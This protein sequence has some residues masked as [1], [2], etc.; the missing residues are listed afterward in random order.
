MLQKPYQLFQVHASDNSTMD[1]IQYVKLCILLI[2][3]LD[4]SLIGPNKVS[5]QMNISQIA[6]LLVS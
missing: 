2:A 5:D 6:L 1:L 4:W 3:A